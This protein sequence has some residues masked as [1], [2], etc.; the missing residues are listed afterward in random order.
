MATEPKSKNITVPSSH[1]GLKVIPCDSKADR[2]KTD[3]VP[4]RGLK[5]ISKETPSSLQQKPGQSLL[6]QLSALADA[7]DADVTQLLKL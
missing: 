5:V 7:I 2:R 6:G 1:R 4:R 3:A